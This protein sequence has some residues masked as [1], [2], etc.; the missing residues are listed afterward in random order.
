[1]VSVSVYSRFLRGSRASNMSHESKNS[2]ERKTHGRIKR[3]FL[4]NAMIL[5]L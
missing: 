1:M 4:L 2:C 5:Q 3:I